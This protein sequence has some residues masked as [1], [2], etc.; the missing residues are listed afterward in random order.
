MT[1][2]VVEGADQS[3]FAAN[4]HRPL[5]KQIKAEPVARLSQVVDVTNHMPVIEKHAIFFQI[6]HGT[7]AVAPSGQAIPVPGLIRWH[8]VFYDLLLSS[9]DQRLEHREMHQT[10]L[11]CA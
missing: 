2:G 11:L 4:H 5:T 1:A 3:I 7:A 8:C 6:Q 10:W 9:N